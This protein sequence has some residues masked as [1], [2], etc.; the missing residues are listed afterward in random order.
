MNVGP[1]EQRTASLTAG[2]TSLLAMS[3]SQDNDDDDGWAVLMEEPKHVDSG[4]RT[5]A[6][7]TPCAGAAGAG[8]AGNRKVFD[9]SAVER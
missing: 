6:A 1:V 8:A 4:K 5:P 2:G 3:H 7:A 9:A